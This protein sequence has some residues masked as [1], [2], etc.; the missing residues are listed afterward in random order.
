MMIELNYFY[1]G[2][3]YKKKKNISKAIETFKEALRII[4][5]KLKKDVYQK[6]ESFG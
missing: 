1:M 6:N 5:L 2:R 3:I 4:E